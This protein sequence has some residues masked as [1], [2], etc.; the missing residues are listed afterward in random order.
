MASGLAQAR[1]RERGESEARLKNKGRGGRKKG[2]MGVTVPWYGK[3][4]IAEKKPA[5][6]A[7]ETR[8]PCPE[9]GL[10]LGLLSAKPLFE[11]RL[12]GALGH[13]RYKVRA[14]FRARVQVG[15]QAFFLLL[16][17]RH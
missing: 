16:D 12:D 2:D 10:P 14:V 5:D 15:V 13:D 9:R 11:R 1:S 4:N 17:A 6:T 8:L 3:S 7:P